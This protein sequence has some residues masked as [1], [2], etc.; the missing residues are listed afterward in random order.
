MRR[1]PVASTSTTSRAST[2]S[3]RS[4]AFGASK[5]AGLLFTFELARRLEDSG[6]TANAVHPGLVRTNL[7]RQALAPLRWATRLVSAP[8]ARAAAAIVPLA[9]A[10]EY[11][12][13]TGRF[14]KGGREIEPPPYTRDPDVARRLWDVCTSLTKPGEGVPA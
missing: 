10:P 6:V 1:P 3:A 12:G 14:F 5:A 4:R 7:M 13:K 11:E 2:A 9:L 8:P